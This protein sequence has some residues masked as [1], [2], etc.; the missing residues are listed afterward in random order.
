MDKHEDDEPEFT[1]EQLR[2]ALKD[3]GEEAR[4]EA[5]AAG[6]PIIIAKDGRLVLLYADGSEEDAGPL[7]LDNVPG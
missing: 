6:L 4:R 3:V 5:F 7:K 1:E 2:A